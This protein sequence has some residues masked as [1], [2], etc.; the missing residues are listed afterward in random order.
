MQ[1]A[2]PFFPSCSEVNSAGYSEFDEPISAR[3]QHTVLVYTNLGYLTLDII[4]S[5]KLT[6]FSGATLSENYSLVHEQVSFFSCQIY[7]LDT[8]SD[9]SGTI[10][11]LPSY[12]T[13][14]HWF[15]VNR[16]EG[17]YVDQRPWSPHALPY[18]LAGEM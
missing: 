1:T 13:I 3:V 7:S 4:C 8:K 17:K 9:S 16:T 2:T 11:W 14:R 12:C 5:S 18:E 10:V 6:F 15:I